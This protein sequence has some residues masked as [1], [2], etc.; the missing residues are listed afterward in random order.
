MALFLALAAFVAFGMYAI[1]INTLAANLWPHF[2][3]ENI[4][5]PVSEVLVPLWNEGLEPHSLARAWFRV[6]AVHAVIVLTIAG[7]GLALARPVE[8]MPRTIAAFV[9]GAGVAVLLVV[10][11]KHWPVHPKGERNLAYI[12]RTWEPEPGQMQ[13]PR[14]VRLR[15]L[16]P[17]TKG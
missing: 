2:D 8:V 15:R 1:I 10:M 12:V 9:F 14:S 17:G 5:H 6:D 3:V 11:T 4:H 13:P 16:P 7:G